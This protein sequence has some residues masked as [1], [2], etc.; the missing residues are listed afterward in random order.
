MPSN[1]S[2]KKALALI[3]GE[4][5]KSKVLGLKVGKHIVEPGQYAPKAG[6]VTM[7]SHRA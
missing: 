4:N 2:V 1:E 5:G 7:T 6:K 3:E